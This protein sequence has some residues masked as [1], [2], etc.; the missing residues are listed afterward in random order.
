MVRGIERKRALG[1]RLRGVERVSRTK[2]CESNEDT[3]VVRP[4]REHSLEQGG[5]LV[6]SALEDLIL[7]ANDQ[8]IQRRESFEVLQGGVQV[9]PPFPRGAPPGPQSG[10]T[11]G[12]GREA[13]S[14]L[15]RPPEPPPPPKEAGCGPQTDPL[16]G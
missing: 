8:L 3:F 4:H 15:A 11:Q 14:G 10:G 16:P 13:P 2:L 9:A 6:E 1:E 5:R 12:G 7:G